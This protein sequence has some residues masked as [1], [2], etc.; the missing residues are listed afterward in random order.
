MSN[1]IDRLVQAQQLAMSIRPKIG[2]FPVLAE[3][4]SQAGVLF[5]SWTLPACQSLYVMN[6]GSV[7]QQ[8]PPIITK[9]E[10]V[11][12]FDRNALVKAIRDD[13]E[14]LTDFPEFLNR[15]WR[16]GIIGY[17]VDFTAREVTYFGIDGE[18]YSEEYP[19]VEIKNNK[20]V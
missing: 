18:S 17:D 7:V 11:P 2:G 6:D 14:G 4:L 1:K 3:V 16:A 13:Q 8:L 20:L 10:E 19:A 9:P 5:N 12:P 15:V